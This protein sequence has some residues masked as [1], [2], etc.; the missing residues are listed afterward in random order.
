MN[1]R[2]TSER[3]AD[4]RPSAANDAVALAERSPPD[5]GTAAVRAVASAAK[6]AAPACAAA[7]GPR[8]WT[9][10]LVTLT[11]GSAI[12]R[13]LMR[14]AGWK[15]A[16]NGLPGRQG[17][18]MV[19]P[20]TSNWDFP[21]GVFTKWSLGFRLRFWAKD[22][23]F[24]L[25][26]VGHWMRGIGGVAVNRREATG[27]VG[28]TVE[29]IRQARARDD[30]YWLIVAPEGTRGYVDSWKSGAY[31]VAVQSGVPVGL[32]SFDYAT[33]TVVF[34]DFVEVSGDADRD[35]ALFAEVLQG[36]RGKHQDQAGAIRLR[37]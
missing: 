3:D 24:K 25:P 26:I 18:V 15:I 29:Q 19:Y 32:A 37:R 27:L 6:A 11:G 30:W 4:Q 16:F 7:A 14:L 33:R 2:Q 35:F 17:V 28:Q 20:H 5:P 10:P 34:T 12:A 23:L 13:W 21:I 22:S 9:G 1:P 36:R 31:H 8:R